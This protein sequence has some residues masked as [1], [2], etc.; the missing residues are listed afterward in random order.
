[1]QRDVTSHFPSPLRFLADQQLTV[2]RAAAIPPAQLPPH[3]RAPHQARRPPPE[4]PFQQPI[5]ALNPSAPKPVSHLTRNCSVHKSLPPA[6]VL[7]QPTPYAQ[8]N[9]LTDPPRRAA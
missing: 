9:T 8:P 1:M 4:C 6:P 7:V 2:I 3:P 5:R